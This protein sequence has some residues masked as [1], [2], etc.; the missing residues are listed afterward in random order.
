M[1]FVDDEPG[2]TAWLGAHP[3]GY[4]LNCDR[5]PRADYVMLHRASCPTISGTPPRGSTWTRTYRKVC[6]ETANELVVWA[7]TETGGSTQRCHA[8]S[9]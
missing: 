1:N 4:V 7:S 9:P 5:T 8:C 3:N 2:Y 6:A